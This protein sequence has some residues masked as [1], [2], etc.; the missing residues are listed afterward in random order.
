MNAFEQETGVVFLWKVC[1][2]NLIVIN[3]QEV[4][5]YYCYYYYYFF[6][7]KM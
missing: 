3:M 4:T 1:Y 7:F 2:E 6:I 5:Y